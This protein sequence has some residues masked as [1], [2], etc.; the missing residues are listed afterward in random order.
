[1]I[2]L[3]TSGVTDT[4]LTHISGNKLMLSAVENLRSTGGEECSYLICHGTRPVV[5]FAQIS[6]RRCNF[7]ERAFP[8]LFPWGRGGMESLRQ[9]GVD[10]SEHVRWALRY[11]DRRF[12]T[13]QTF[14]FVAFGIQQ[15]R[16]ALNSTRIQMN[17]QSFEREARC[18]SSITHSVLKKAVHEE[19]LR[20][21][22]TDPNVCLLKKQIFAAA[23]NVQGSDQSRTRLRSQ[24][25]STAVFLGPP[26]LW[27]T[28]NPCDLHDP[29]VQVFAGEN[30]DVDN[31]STVNN[32]NK[33]QRARNVARDP[34]VAAK[35][36]HTLICIVLDTLCG[37]KA[38]SYSI[39][40]KEGVF[41]KVAGY[42]GTVESQGRGSLH[43]HMLIYLSGVP[44]SSDLEAALKMEDFRRHVIN[45]L[46]H[47]IHAEIPGVRSKDDP[48]QVMN[49][50]EI[51]W[52]RPPNLT[53][54]D[55]W[56]AIEVE[57]KEREVARAKQVREIFE[58]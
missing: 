22:I 21:P 41:G 15:H 10:L 11:H 23:S 47:N 14:I 45:F 16:Q 49:N 46:K 29:I 6:D 56:Y 25:W 27:I 17:R 2:P 58:R 26:S 44:T 32:V 3:Q 57:K 35:Y 48:S 52:S 34:Y 40:R 18:L 42:F 19:Q 1:M 51:A 39:H 43:L 36:F 20:M 31:L 4:E 37:I 5:D 53:L 55:S 24:L 54:T 38:T 8:C 28:I 30:V 9:Q 33:E 7:F 50:T 13:H 12:R